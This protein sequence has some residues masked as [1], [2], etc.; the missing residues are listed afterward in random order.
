VLG[1]LAAPRDST[2]AASLKA[3]EKIFR[4]FFSFFQKTID[5]A[6]ILW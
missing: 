4:P 6:R 2:E 5:T 1:V 3:F